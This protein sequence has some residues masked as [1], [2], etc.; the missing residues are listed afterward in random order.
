[1]IFGAYPCCD[2]PL[3]IAMTEKPG[4]I[5]ELCPNCGTPVW[6]RM[7]R[8]D[9]ESWTEEQ[10]LKEHRVDEETKQIISLM[11]EARIE[12]LLTPDQLQELRNRMERLLLYGDGSIKPTGLITR[13]EPPQVGKKAEERKRK[14]AE[15]Q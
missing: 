7:S 2:A 15:G 13:T 6:H 5:R 4:F 10:F 11:P 12:D 8:F 14:E 9:P 3:S 1:M